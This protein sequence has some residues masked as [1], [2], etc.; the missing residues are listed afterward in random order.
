MNNNYYNNY[1]NSLPPLPPPLDPYEMEVKIWHNKKKE[2]RGTATILAVIAGIFNMILLPSC[3][4]CGACGTSFDS[5]FTLVINL[6][7]AVIGIALII[8]AIFFYRN[9]N[10][11]YAKILLIV[12][13]VYL[14]E[15]LAVIIISRILNYENLFGFYMSIGIVWIV[16]AIVV[17]ANVAS[18]IRLDSKPPER[19]EIA[20][21][22]PYKYNLEKGYHNYSSN[23][24]QTSLNSSYSTITQDSK[25][26]YAQF[27]EEAIAEEEPIKV[28]KRDS[29]VEDVEII[30]TKQEI[31]RST[32]ATEKPKVATAEQSQQQKKEE[33]P[34]EENPQKEPKFKF[35]S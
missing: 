9:K 8:S 5:N 14:L 1:N 13:I 15:K 17:I 2:T 21:F 30:Q 7:S 34:N 23:T 28:M 25:D 35:Y 26:Y 3:T 10:R 22:N 24:Q 20:T 12:A 19:K 32:I 18:Y 29:L 33:K 16:L 27:G 31:E 6:L 4:A 11:F